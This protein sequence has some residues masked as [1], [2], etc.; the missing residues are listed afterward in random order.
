LSK[1]IITLKGLLLQKI[2][3]TLSCKFSFHIIE[4]P[5]SNR[6]HSSTLGRKG[7]LA[8]V[9][10]KEKLKVLS[11]D[12]DQRTSIPPFWKSYNSY[13]LFI[14]LVKHDM[15]FKNKIRYWPIIFRFCLWLEWNMWQQS[16]IAE[17]GLKFSRTYQK[18]ASKCFLN[19]K[20]LPLRE[21]F[22][23]LL[24]VRFQ[25]YFGACVSCSLLFSAVN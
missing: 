5:I 4:I 22:D 16:K 9:R 20:T 13:S 1:Q 17:W 18:C 10:S 11:F 19:G 23:M 6:R 24:S 7:S 14:W 21:I 3:E 8:I 15:S 25:I 2:M 12:F